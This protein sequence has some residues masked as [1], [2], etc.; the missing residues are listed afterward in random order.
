MADLS[1]EDLTRLAALPDHFNLTRMAKELQHYRAMV[2]RLNEWAEQ[3]EV[4]Q[5]G[6]VGVGSFVA[7]ELRY[8]MRGD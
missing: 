8:R 7:A 3:L 5:F 2:K 1:D 4:S 6:G